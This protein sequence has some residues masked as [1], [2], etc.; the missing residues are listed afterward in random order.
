MNYLFTIISC[1]FHSS[2][3]STFG[4]S[5]LF[6][7]LKENNTLNLKYK[8]IPVSSFR[9]TGIYKANLRFYTKRFLNNLISKIVNCFLLI[10]II[11]S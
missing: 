4:N 2:I 10:V 7:K 3:G 5:V 1:L 9:I 8:K 6:F 11:P